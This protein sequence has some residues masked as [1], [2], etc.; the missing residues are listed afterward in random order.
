LS[1]DLVE[2]LDLVSDESVNLLIQK[3]Y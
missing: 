2:G 3:N 1:P